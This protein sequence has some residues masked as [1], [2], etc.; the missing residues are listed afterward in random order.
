LE[1]HHPSHSREQK[2]RAGESKREQAVHTKPTLRDGAL[3]DK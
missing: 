1:E 3:G 2:E